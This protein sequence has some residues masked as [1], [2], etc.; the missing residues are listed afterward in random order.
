[1]TSEAEKKARVATDTAALPTVISGYEPTSTSTFAIKGAA[2]VL[3]PPLFIL[4]VQSPQTGIMREEFCL[5]RR[6]QVFTIDTWHVVST[7]IYEIT[8]SYDLLS[9]IAFLPTGLL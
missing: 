5:K 6:W 8:F 3:I 4:D 1:M 9:L 7:T 2:N